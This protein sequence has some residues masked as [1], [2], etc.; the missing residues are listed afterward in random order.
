MESFGHIAAA[1]ASMLVF[2]CFHKEYGFLED[3]LLIVFQGV[4]AV[5]EC[6][7]D[8]GFLL[9]RGSLCSEVQ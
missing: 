3:A 9:D 5:M 7:A 2:L 8:A 1:A 4:A 6:V